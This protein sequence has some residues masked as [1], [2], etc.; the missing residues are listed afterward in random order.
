ML[1]RVTHPSE[2]LLSVFEVETHLLVGSVK[3]RCCHVPDAV[4]HAGL[5]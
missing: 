1:G 3:L 5:E 4:V 2:P